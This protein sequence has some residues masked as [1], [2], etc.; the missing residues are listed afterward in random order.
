MTYTPLS[1]EPENAEV[2]YE[3]IYSNLSINAA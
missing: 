2:F 1:S 3:G